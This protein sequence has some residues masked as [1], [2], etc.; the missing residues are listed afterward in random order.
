M[1]KV[2]LIN[3]LKTKLNNEKVLIACSTGVDSVVLLNL[4]EEA[5]PINNIVIAHVNH[6]V[7]KESNT[8]EAYI[9]EYANNKNIKIYITSLPSI[10]NNFENN[11]R[12][13][14][15]E[16]FYDVAKK[17]HIKYILTAHH[18]NDNLETIIMRLIKKSSLKGY[19]GI[20]EEQQ[21]D[22]F[23]LYRPLINIKKS[24]LITYAKENNLKYFD[25]YTNY[26]DIH[27]RNRIR[28][29]IIPK[30]EEEN[31][32][33]SSAISYYSNTLNEASI[34]IDNNINKYIKDSVI[35]LD[36]NK[37]IKLEIDKIINEDLFFQ[38]QLIFKILK[39]FELS[40]PCI[41][42]II[43]N[44][45]SSNNKIVYN[46]NNELN[47]IKEYGYILFTTLSIKPLEFN[48]E[49]KKEGKYLLPNNLELNVERNICY[50]T[51]NNKKIWYN[52]DD[53][54]FVI[55]TRYKEDKIRRYKKKDNKKI[56]YY[57]TLSDYLTN[58]KVPYLKRINLLYIEIN[59]VIINILDDKL[60]I[61]Q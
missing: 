51:T 36:N 56:I 21:I 31:P 50:L 18:Y 39:P 45:N 49:I 40:I 57:Q 52:I 55:R 7:R 59:N 46:I 11:A 22:D 28:K 54:N 58:K 47:F 37:T 38:K 42:E 33:L 41:D 4:L 27:T 13:K 14:R 29:Y 3:T 16:F 12:E 48:L 53:V 26:D 34:Y 20:I 17:E 9:K 35:Y 30:L 19:A 8:E 44:I 25:D 32:N 15:Y 10:T 23:I 6:K 2:K 60:Y 5:L 61:K 24:D 43:K 1:D